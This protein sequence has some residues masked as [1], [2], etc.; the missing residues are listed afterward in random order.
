MI[1]KIYVNQ[2]SGRY[3]FLINDDSASEIDN[4]DINGR[5]QDEASFTYY[6]G[7]GR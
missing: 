4:N 6:N 5:R 1:E 3:L 2:L 7:R